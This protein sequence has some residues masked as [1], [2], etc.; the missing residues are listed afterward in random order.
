MF[1]TI[2][3]KLEAWLAVA[4]AVALAVGY[5]FLKGRTFGKT[6]SEASLNKQTQEAQVALDKIDNQPIDFGSA[7]SKLR[8]RSKPTLGGPLP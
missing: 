5:A 3:G 7:V 6:E 1:A 4:G 2:K 8:Q